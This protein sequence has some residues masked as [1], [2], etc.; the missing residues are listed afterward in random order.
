MVIPCVLVRY[1]VLVAYFELC[2]SLDRHRVC[3][4]RGD[5]NFWQ[6]SH[7]HDSIM[8]I[9]SPVPAFLGALASL[10]LYAFRS[11]DFTCAS[12]SVLPQ[13]QQ[14]PSPVR[15]RST[16]GLARL[17]YRTVMSASSAARPRGH[18]SFALRKAAAALLLATLV[19]LPFAVLYRATVSRSLKDSW[20][21]DSLTSV[22]ASEEEEEGAEAD[23][24]VSTALPPFY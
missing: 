7:L 3:S 6:P 14:P 23:G 9:H 13:G 16:R 11:R 22:A 12:V 1:F 18:P 21:L 2:P 10:L 4:S 24:L 19:A 8:T 20:G 5:V 15:H 17:L